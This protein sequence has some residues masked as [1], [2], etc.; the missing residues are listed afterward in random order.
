MPVIRRA[1]SFH[2]TEHIERPVF[3]LAH[4]MIGHDFKSCGIFAEAGQKSG[5]RLDV[6]N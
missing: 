2:G 5:G 6:P 4:S 1:K 3:T